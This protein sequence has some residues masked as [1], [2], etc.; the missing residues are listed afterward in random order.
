MV[1][2]TRTPVGGSYAS[3]F[4]YSVPHFHSFV[5]IPIRTPV[6]INGGV[7]ELSSV[8]CFS[9]PVD[10]SRDVPTTECV[11]LDLGQGSDSRGDI[12]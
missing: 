12:N 2:S 8:F 6:R 9:S 3:E 11:S 1:L 7:D 4:L 10:R 5:M